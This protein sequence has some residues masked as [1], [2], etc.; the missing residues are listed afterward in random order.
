MDDLDSLVRVLE[1]S[2][3]RHG[4]KPLTNRWLLNIIKMSQR[5]QSRKSRMDDWDWVTWDD[6][7]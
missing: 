4:E 3:E 5:N 7:F 2:V 1:S 6:I